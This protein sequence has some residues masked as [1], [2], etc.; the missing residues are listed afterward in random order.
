MIKKILAR[1][2]SFIETHPLSTNYGID[3]LLVLG[4][5]SIAANNSNLFAQRLGAGDFHLSMLQFLPHIINLFLLIPVG[6]MVDSLTNKRRIVSILL[7]IAGLFFAM[8]GM[9]AFVP[10]HAVYFFIIVVGLANVSIGGLF[11]MTWQAFFP[12]AVSEEG[13]ENRNAV[14]TFRA[15]MTMIVSLIAPLTVGF[16]LT[17]IPSEGGKI[18]AHQ[19]FYL[20]AA[21]L[22]VLNSLH[23][24][25]IIAV[26]PSL[27]KRFSMEEIKIAGRRLV[28][29]KT[30]IVFTLV[31]FFFHM[32][33]HI[34][35]TL[36]FIAQ[37]NYLLMNEL[38]L[39]LTPV[40]GMLAQLITLR[41]WS[42][43]NT[44]QG[45]ELPLVYGMMGLIMSPIAVIVGTNLPLGFGPWVF[46]LLHGMGQLAFTNITLNLFQCLLKV[47]DNEYRSLFISM[48]TC[49]IT[50]SNAVMPVVGVMIYRSLGADLRALQLTFWIILGIRIVAVCLWLLRLKFKVKD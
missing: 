18:I 5:V 23:F 46:L 26:S 50:L 10:I 25:K 40:V 48:Y 27:P 2:R 15:R 44:K 32:G 13:H 16:V 1:G 14:L 34:D 47:V 8:A 37:A 28:R 11:N 6:M 41:F 45:V 38:M 4:G 22:L 35:W 33:W 42:R 49:L 7:V 29:N 30:F 20:I 31:I 36:F 43:N 9:S 3:G 21:V 39:S 12:E 19:V 17:R 24:R